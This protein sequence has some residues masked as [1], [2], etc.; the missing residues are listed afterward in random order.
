MG[1]IVKKKTKGRPKKADSISG[2]VHEAPPTERDLR[3]SHRRR[4]VKYFFD[5]D[6]YFDDDEIF[7]NDE[8]QRRKQKQLKL[9]LKLESG[10]ELAPAAPQPSRT[11]RVD[12]LT[13]TSASSFGEDG[14]KPPKRPKI[15]DENGGIN[16][17][18]DCY[19]KENDK[20][21]EKM[22]ELVAQ[23]SPTA[24]PLPDKNAL[25]LIL[26]KLQKKDVYGVYAEPV[27]SKELPDYYDLIKYPMDF[28]T[29]RRKLQ[30]G[31]YETLE[32]FEHDV[33][34]ICSNA[35]Q[36][37]E[38]HTV[39]HKQARSI[40]E[41]ATKEFQ[42]IR[43][44]F[45]C[46]EKFVKPEQ[47]MKYSYTLNMQTNDSVRRMVQES[48]GS[49]FSCGA[50]LA[51]SADIH[52][53]PNLP[54]SVG[55]FRTGN[56][57]VL[58]EGKS[59]LNDNNL[60]KGEES[61]PAY[62]RTPFAHQAIASDSIF[63]TFEGE[64]KHLVPVGLY[65]ENSYARSLARFAATLGTV[66]WKVASKKIEQ[67][68][69]QGLEFGRGWI[70]E[71]EP[72]PN[73]LVMEVSRISETEASKHLGDGNVFG[74]RFCSSKIASSSSDVAKAA[75]YSP[76]PNDSS[77]ASVAAARAW[78]SV[79]SR[80]FVPA[81]KNANL[82]KN[83]IF[84]NS[85]YNPTPDNVAEN[86]GV[87]SAFGRNGMHVQLERNDSLLRAFVDQSP[88]AFRVG[89]EIQQSSWRNLGPQMHYW[90]KQELLPPDLNIGFQSLGS[91]GLPSLLIDSPDL[92]LQL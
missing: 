81:G 52:N 12:Q 58:S 35:M 68:L 30:N 33:F 36:Y 62:T 80:G 25:E 7:E 18:V 19:N 17:G 66:A 74:N 61:L 77:S 71:Y 46:S 84:P 64:S 11:R 76:Q 39:Y 3:R 14:G 75:T 90:Q 49:D 72:L 92:A 51:T 85:S 42:K 6:D 38:R 31:S 79:G 34:L 9:L 4:N 86:R 5:L 1:Q 26:D 89:N 91:L 87:R 57:D 37:N 32:N 63:S 29:V 65:S 2:V 67:S 44:N 55:I 8:D 45:V 73:P 23:D 69:P 41:L 43:L 13:S 20:V 27:D 24:A 59:F 47:K 10:G 53:V 54:Q 15:D 28:A 78:M 22:A 48:L 16:A 60:D 21:R 83:Q 56:S 82:H 40:K 70:G 50:T 88:R